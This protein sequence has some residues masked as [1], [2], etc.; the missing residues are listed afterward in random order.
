MKHFFLILLLFFASQAWSQQLAFVFKG[1]I[2][3]QDLGKKEGGVKVSIVQGGTTVASTTSSSNGKY[4]LTGTANYR[5]PFTVVF[6]KGGL[7]SKMVRFNLSTLNEEDIPPGEEYRPVESLDMTMFGEREYADFSF[8]ENEP[9][10]D[11]EWNEKKLRLGYDQAASNRVRTKIEELLINAEKK[12]AEMEAKYQAAISAADEAYNK[13]EY[14]KALSKYEE[15]LTYKPLEPYPAERILELDALL[16][17]QKEQALAQ[18]QADAKYNNLIAAADNLRD[19]GELEKAIAK[20]QEAITEKDEQYPKDQIAALKAQIEAKKKEAENQAKY[21]EAIKA[22]DGFL[23][24]NS[25]RAARDKYKEASELKPSEKYPKDKLA[26]IENKLKAKEEQEALKQKYDEAIAAGDAAF[27]SDDFETAK[28]KYEEALTYEASSTYA[29]ERI[30]MCDT[31]LADAKAEQERLAKI[32]E[33]LK[34]G[35]DEFAKSDLELAKATFE[36]VLTLDDKNAPAT[37]KIAEIDKLLADAEAQA[38]KDAEFNKLVQEGDAANSSND[39]QTALTKYQAAIAV[40]PSPE[41]DAKIKSVQEKLANE[42]AAAEQKAKY[43]QFIADATAKMTSGDLTGA[44]SDFENASAID[45]SQ[46]LPKEKIAEIEKMLADQQAAADQKAKYDQFITDATAKMT[47]G[48]L[49]GAKTDFESASAIDPSQTLPKEKIAEIDKMLAEEQAAADQKAKYDQFIAD[50]TAKMTSG[51]LTGAKT[52]YESASAIDPSQNLPKEKIAEIEKILADE[53]AAADQKAKYDQFIAD[54]ASKMTSG[55]LEGAKSDYESASAIDPSQTLP[56][57]KIAEIDKILAEKSAAEEKENQYTQL[58]SEGQQLM[59]ADDLTQAKSKFEEA[60]AI[61]PSEAE[62]KEKLAEIEKL[63]QEK[64]AAQDQQ[65]QYNELIADAQ[66]KFGADNLTGAKAAY[67]EAQNVDPSQTLP[68][69]KIAEIDSI[70]A[71]REAEKEA[72][73]LQKLEYQA[74]IKAGDDLL[75]NGKLEEAKSKFQEAINIDG[76]QNYPKDKITQIESLLANQEANAAKQEQIA[77]LIVE[78]NDRLNSNDLVGAKAKFNE[79]LNL[80]PGNPEAQAQLQKIAAQIAAEQSQA[81]KDEDYNAFLTEGANKLANRD[82][83]GAISA[84][85]SASNVKPNESLPKDKIEEIKKLMAEESAASQEEIEANYQKALEEGKRLMASENYLGAIKSFNEALNYKPSE[86]E[87]KELAAEAEKLERERGEVDAQYEKILTVAQKKIDEQ[88]YDRAVELLNRAKSFK[89]E[90]NRPDQMLAEIEQ[91]RKVEENYTAAIAEGADKLLKNDLNAALTAYQRASKIKPNEA[92]PKDKIDE[93]KSLIAQSNSEAKADEIYADN[94]AKGQMTMDAKRF[95]EALGYYKNA[96]NVK[97]GDSRAQA[98]I[99]EVQQIL[100]NLANADEEKRKQKEEFDRLIKEADALFAEEKY[101]PFAKNKYEE[102][103]AIMPNNSYALT[104]RDESIRLARNKVDEEKEKQYQKLIAAADKSFGKEDYTKAKDYYTRAVNFKSNDPYPKQKLQEIEG[105]LNPVVV[106][107][108]ELEDLGDPYDGSIIDGAFLLEKAEEERAF[109]KGT[110]IQ[111]EFDEIQ[112]ASEEM[113]AKK[114]EDRLNTTNEIYQLQRRIRVETIDSDESRKATVEALRAAERERD[115]LERSNLQFEKSEN[116]TSQGQLDGI[117]ERGAIAYGED[118]AV[119]RDNA[120][121]VEVYN[122]SAADLMKEN[123]SRKMDDN[124]FA[125]GEINKIKKAI[126][127]DDINDL[128]QRLAEKQKVE[129]IYLNVESKSTE[130]AKMA[131]EN[132]TSIKT[133]Q[134]DVSDMDIQRSAI[135]K[136]HAFQTDL[137]VADVKRR[138]QVD[139]SV[140]IANREESTEK[141]KEIKVAYEEASLDAYNKETE[142]YLKNK[143]I[144]DDEEARKS[145]IA[146]KA[147]EAHEKKVAYMEG[148]DK[149]VNIEN[150]AATLSDQEERQN[151]RKAVENIQLAQ[152]TEFEEEKKEHVENIEKLKDV[153]KT[154]AADAS[155]EAARQKEK[156]YENQTAISKVDDTPKPKKK[157]ANALGEEYPEGVSQESFTRKDQ[158]GLV[159][160]VITRRI[161]VIEGHADVYVRTQSKNGITYSKNGIPSLEH[162]WNSETQSP[163]LERHF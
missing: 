67:Q 100:D 63:L 104:Q 76:T 28:S 96:L 90:D 136:D 56:K 36:E 83:Q 55:D 51:D 91:L 39:L 99:D 107:S 125:D 14:E 33:L 153:S 73:E 20:Y 93:I 75:A 68:S 105:I 147:N 1:Q 6:S 27:S 161:V 19:G 122:R 135:E 3:N 148:V 120:A 64:R 44:K 50:A 149:K 124:R 22:A 48:D 18:Q 57:E 4:S 16:Q 71:Q 113:S 92:L 10:A 52:D 154:A 32:D 41:V 143:Q 128:D 7:V 11:F 121:S 80:D 30:K 106:G 129:D 133:I 46:T 95:D 86:S 138:A 82:Y 109:L 85:Q 72:A 70:L 81:Q 34:K 144:L 98:K 127:S 116:L 130:D 89:P 12:K 131:S 42:Q 29:K 78:G 119:Y 49:V 117:K 43:D 103:L 123:A 87:P 15:A 140:Y 21:D 53:Q 26:E 160:A 108:V 54:A 79:V 162:V 163:D 40:K 115:A 151:A 139:A 126:V 5:Q 157:V 2:E 35:N 69:E 158:N 84:Y 137:E 8:L 45:P 110:Q 141:F 156:T 132:G 66:A 58:I 159:T 31:A 24:Q 152:V 65:T 88:D 146:E 97:P 38:Q 155:N 77:Q 101:V 145:D 94:M 142:K 60:L 62:P 17:S 9:V 13:K 118:L 61:K 47:A 59:S 114:T 112:S 25:L 37:A 74:A 134:S 102:A 111:R 23:K 150:N